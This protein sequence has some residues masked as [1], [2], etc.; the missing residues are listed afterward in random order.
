MFVQTF[1]TNTGYKWQKGTQ[2]WNGSPGGGG[3]LAVLKMGGSLTV[4]WKK[5]LDTGMA[6]NWDEIEFKGKMVPVH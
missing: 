1:R 5:D 6:L 4:A 2:G 3:F